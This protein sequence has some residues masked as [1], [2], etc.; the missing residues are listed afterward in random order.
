MPELALVT[1]GETGI[2]RAIAEALRGDGFEVRSASRRSGFD[3]TD[4]ATIDR[5]V[6]SLPRLDV[7]V[8]NAG[9]GESA[10][11]ARTTDEQWDRHLALN[12]TAPLLL[13]RAALPLLRQAP[14]GR[15]INVASTAGR[16]G[17]P[18]VAAYAASKQALLGL[19]RVLA[20]ELKDVAV[21]AV[22]P[23]FVDSP[24]TDRSVR[25][26][27]A[28]TGKSEAE[29]RAALAALNPGG[30]LLRPEEVA[31]AVL[32]LVHAP[33]TGREVELG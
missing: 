28:L 13:C 21:H 8:N 1:G 10:P 32:D 27:V 18:Y 6:E 2:G 29:A 25:H 31:A 14:R 30:R 7:L 9:I 20:V 24:L 4:R 19:T 33:D 23:G 15:I 12:V 22:C 3:L 5:L 26:I 17:S 11:L 16:E